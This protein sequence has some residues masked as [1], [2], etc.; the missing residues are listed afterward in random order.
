MTSKLL[1]RTRELLGSTLIPDT[2]LAR[3]VGC[4]NKT[5]AAIREG[6]NV[7]SVELCEKVYNLLSKHALEVK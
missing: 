6:R 3:A 4:S 1:T 2:R 5:I 7:P